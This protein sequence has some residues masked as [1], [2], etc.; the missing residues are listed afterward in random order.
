[1]KT[2]GVCE[3]NVKTNLLSVINSPPKGTAPARLATAVSEAEREAALRER[4]AAVTTL[5]ARSG[6]VLERE[7]IDWLLSTSTAEQINELT[8]LAWWRL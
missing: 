3:I 1:M 4:E 7:A 5:E 6:F 8:E 2:L